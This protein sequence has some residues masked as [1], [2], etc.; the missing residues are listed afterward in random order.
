MALPCPALMMTHKKNLALPC[1]EGRA[2]KLIF[3]IKRTHILSKTFW[4]S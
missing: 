2:Y 4:L 3:T 1:P